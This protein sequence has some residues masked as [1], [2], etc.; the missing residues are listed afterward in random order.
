MPMGQATGVRKKGQSRVE[1]TGFY[2]KNESINP[3]TSV[4]FYRR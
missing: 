3:V 1:E 2:A 4:I